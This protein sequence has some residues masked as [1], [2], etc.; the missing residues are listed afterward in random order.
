MSRSFL[1]DICDYHLS[2]LGCSNATT[3][4]STDTV[5]MILNILSGIGYF[6]FIAVRFVRGTILKEKRF[7]ESK[8]DLDVVA[9]LGGI[10]VLLRSGVL[11]NLRSV[12]SMN[13]QT[14]TDAEA[15]SHVRTTLIIEAVQI[16]TG[17]LAMSAF[18]NTM[19]KTATG[20][21]L[22]DPI[23][24]GQKIIDPG[25]A[26]K[27]FR[28]FVLLATITFVCLLSI[29]GVNGSYEQY[30]VYRRLYYGLPAFISVFVSLPLLTVFGFKVIGVLMTSL[31]TGYH[32]DGTEHGDSSKK[33][34]AK[35]LNPP[36]DLGKTSETSSKPVKKDKGKEGKVL[37]LRISIYGVM[38]M[39]GFA[40]IYF[41]CIAAV[42]ELYPTQHWSLY[43][44]KIILDSFFWL[45]F[46]WYIQLS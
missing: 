2:Y 35:A 1:F 34:A 5:L 43:T 37:M 8:K 26:L 18:I 44:T 16:I 7:K 12:Q 33:S 40:A 9:L 45:Y 17:S 11:A 21:N 46:A 32:D 15:Q 25:K 13:V 36:S 38:I 39:Y 19:V 24:I 10:S 6:G 42:N 22:F 28:L 27:L 31:P 41:C 20:A 14:M 23:K 29:I 3:F 30:V 4:A